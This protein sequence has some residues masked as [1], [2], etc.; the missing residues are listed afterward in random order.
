MNVLWIVFYGIHLG[1]RISITRCKTT[2]W[3]GGDLGPRGGRGTVNGE[4]RMK[5]GGFLIISHVA[6]FLQKGERNSRL[7]GKRG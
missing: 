4:T 7:E 3:K 5:L 1:P 6:S 2:V